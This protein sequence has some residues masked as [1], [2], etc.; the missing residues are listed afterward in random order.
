MFKKKRH[1][2]YIIGLIEELC[3]MTQDTEID[4]I[5]L[6]N[7]FELLI[8]EPSVRMCIISKYKINPEQY[9]KNPIES[10][11]VF[12]PYVNA[13][14]KQNNIHNK[15]K[16][17]L[18]HYIVN[19]CFKP[20]EETL[21][22]YKKAI[23]V[24]PV[25]LKPR[26]LNKKLITDKYF[27]V[28]FRYIFEAQG[29]SST[30]IIDN[31]EPCYTAIKVLETLF[32]EI[33]KNNNALALMDTIKRAIDGYKPSIKAIKHLPTIHKR[34]VNTELVHYFLKDIYQ[35]RDQFYQS[36]RHTPLLTAKTN[37]GNDVIPN[38]FFIVKTNTYNNLRTEKYPY[39]LH[40][41]TST[42]KIKHIQKYYR[43]TYGKQ[44][45]NVSICLHYDKKTDQC[46][47]SKA[48][49]IAKNEIINTTVDALEKLLK[50]SCY[51]SIPVFDKS[52]SV[53][54]LSYGKFFLK[55]E[56]DDNN[57]IKSNK[58]Y[59]AIFSCMVSQVIP[60][61]EIPVF[62]TAPIFINGIP[63]LNV[64]I[65][66]NT[67]IINESQQDEDNV[68]VT[69]PAWKR[70]FYFYRSVVKRRITDECHARTKQAY[71]TCLFDIFHQHIQNERYWDGFL[72]IKTTKMVPLFREI[73]AKMDILSR[74]YPYPKVNINICSEKDNIVLIENITY[75]NK[76]N[77]VIKKED[78][79]EYA[80]HLPKT[81]T[82][83][84]VIKISDNDNF[85]YLYGR[86]GY[87][88]SK[89]KTTTLA[90]NEADMKYASWRNELLQGFRS[91]INDVNLKGPIADTKE[92]APLLYPPLADNY[93]DQ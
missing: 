87:G 46:C 82:R 16:K 35:W 57:K 62:T 26:R 13:G 12:S 75:D 93:I 68:L 42:S 15:M 23:L 37:I 86:D 36:Y 90:E 24:I 44:G 88:H 14:N 71:L 85:S 89:K 48:D 40:I 56:I 52:F 51:C 83:K 63:W 17:I 74:I 81:E 6:I 73:N 80:I 77:I 8:Q 58:K 55:K 54:T 22:D 59:Q 61:G 9:P 84:F 72:G 64:T 78:S 5:R 69:F 2:Q 70:S 79:D 31:R 43:N 67:T 18:K 7:R 20:P 28:L 50:G 38:M 3:L 34:E 49:C 19:D 4:L 91:V 47:L 1:I 92:N 76:G 66:S 41:I 25:K 29:E 33:N 53:G 60:R 21:I 65:L 27:I 11:I 45:E 10:H 32:I 39:L 30:A